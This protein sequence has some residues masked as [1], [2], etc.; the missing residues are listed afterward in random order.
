[1]MMLVLIAMKLRH[2]RTKDHTMTNNDYEQSNF[3]VLLDYDPQNFILN[4]NKAGYTNTH[5]VE[6]ILLKILTEL[7]APL[8]AFKDIMDGTCDA[9]QSGYSF[10]P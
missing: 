8:W 4:P 7:E 6:V 1:M 2:P 5:H 3:N 9:Y 10:L